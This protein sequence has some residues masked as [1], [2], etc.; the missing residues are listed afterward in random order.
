MK[1]NKFKMGVCLVCAGLFVIGVNAQPPGGG[2]GPRE[3]R[4]GD[5][6]AAE[7]SENRAYVE[8]WLASIQER[9]PAE[10]ARLLTLREEH[11][12]A[13][14]ME[15]RRRVQEG[16]MLQVIRE[17][18]PGFY[19]YLQGLDQE[20]RD[21]LGNFLQRMATDRPDPERRPRSRF[22]DFADDAELRRMARNWR[23]ADEEERAR[24]RQRLRQHVE[25][26][27]DERTAA[28]QGEVEQLEEQLRRLRT[29]LETRQARRAQWIDQVLERLT[30]LE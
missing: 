25:Q 3:G 16:R 18:F 4:G 28:Q 2:R 21:R 8:R 1:A 6:R 23:E 17:E 22:A 24:L 10:H 9:D 15:M 11:P 14:R 29:L 12:V 19:E 20:E 30:A 5:R 7:V 27:F 13:F 26:L